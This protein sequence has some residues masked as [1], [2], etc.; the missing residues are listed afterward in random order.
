[1]RARWA[2]RR[3][4][5]DYLVY[6]YHLQL[7]R[8]AA[9]APWRRKRSR[10]IAARMPD[11]FRSR[12]CA[13]RLRRRALHG[14]AWRLERCGVTRGPAQQIPRM[15][16][17]LPILPGRLAP[18]GH[19]QDRCQAGADTAKLAGTARQASGRKER[20]LG[21]AGRCSGAAGCRPPGFFMP[22]VVA[23]RRIKAMSAARRRRGQHRKSP[24]TPGI[25]WR[26]RRDQSA[27]GAMLDRGMARAGAC[28]VRR[29]RDG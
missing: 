21:R 1:M 16:W 15:P 2:T 12:V 22:A 7:G 17:L 4:W 3:T 29:P 5:P 6:A 25:P 18:P 14:G 19:R 13:G 27:Y 28:G 20:L 23:M 8:Y 9:E 11:S 24:V 10:G 26:R